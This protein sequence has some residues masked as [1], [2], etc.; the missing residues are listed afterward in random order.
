[1]PTIRHIRPFVPA[2]DFARSKQFYKALGFDVRDMDP[3]LSEVSIGEH[4]FFLQDY[5]Q[6]DWAGNSMLYVLV[7]DIDAWW[8]RIVAADLQ[9][10]FGVPACRPPTAEPW[11]HTVAHVID[12]SGVLLHVASV[13]AAA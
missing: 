10:S 11:G 4:G 3:A 1:M 12:P 9:A 5:Y 8:Q 13:S 2:K 7:D 6:P